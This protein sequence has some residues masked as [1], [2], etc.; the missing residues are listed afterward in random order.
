MEAAIS[1]VNM[2][3]LS[4]FRAMDVNEKIKAVEGAVYLAERIDDRLLIRLYK[5]SNFYV[6]SFS[7]LPRDRVVHFIAFNSNDL[8]LPYIKK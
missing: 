7:E 4:E 8:L 3:T 1:G 6:E 2:I 5:L